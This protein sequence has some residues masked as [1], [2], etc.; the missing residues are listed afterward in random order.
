MTKMYKCVFCLDLFKTIKELKN[1]IKKRH[2]I[3][4]NTKDFDKLEVDID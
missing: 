4:I 1:H 3:R 2:R